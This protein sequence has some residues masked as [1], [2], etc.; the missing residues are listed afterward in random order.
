MHCSKPH[1]RSQG[2]PFGDNA[3]AGHD[4]LEPLHVSAGLHGPDAARHT[5]PA[6]A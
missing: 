3:S 5:V 4:A 2:D 1:R 6:A